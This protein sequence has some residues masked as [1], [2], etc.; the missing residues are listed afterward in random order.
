M[1]TR[2]FIHEA[3]YFIIRNG[4]LARV[5]KDYWCFEDRLVSP[6]SMGV[7]RPNLVNGLLVPREST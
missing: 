7:G 1:A 4:E 2:N 5:F 6:R 3:A